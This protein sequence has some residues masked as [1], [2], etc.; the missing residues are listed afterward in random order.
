[1]MVRIRN[2]TSFF[3]SPRWAARTP[4]TMVKLEIS[5]T[6]GIQ[7]AERALQVLV[8]FD[9]FLRIAGLHQAEAD[10]QAAEQQNFG[11]QEQP[12]TDLAGIEL[13]LH[14]GEVMLMMRIVGVHDARPCAVKIDWS[15]C[16]H[17]LFL[18]RHRFRAVIVR[19]ARAAPAALQNCG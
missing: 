8:R 9:K 3:L 10:E 4:I 18:V 14:R 11:R 13:L 16:A 19:R 1:M 7:R 15:G 5:R 12:H 17:A 2:I 6:I